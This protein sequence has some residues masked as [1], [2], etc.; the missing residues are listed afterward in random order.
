[1]ENSVSLLASSIMSHFP[2]TMTGIA[3]ILAI[4]T[5]TWFKHD[6]ACSDIFLSRLMFFAVGLTGLWGFILNLFFQNIAAQYVGWSPS[7]FQFEVAV[8][9]LG[10]GIAGICGVCASRDYRVATTIFT[11]CFLWGT[12]AGHIREMMTTHNFAL[13]HAGM[14]FYNNLIVPLLLIVFLCCQTCCKSNKVP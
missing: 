9:N 11:T 6:R 13:G 4:I 8:A 10:L 14:I 7:P 1:M 5:T 2:S 12:A 3:I